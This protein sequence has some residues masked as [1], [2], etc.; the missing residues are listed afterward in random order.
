MR[1]NFVDTV[2]L[3]GSCKYKCERCSAYVDAQKDDKIHVSPNVLVLPL[4]RS[5][6]LGRF[7]KITKF[8]S[9][10]M[11]LDLSPYMSPDAPYEGTGPPIYR[12]YSVVVHLG[13]ALNPKP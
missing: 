7:S 12:L 6:S 1:K 4:K 3:E 11:D 5:V 9:F 2:A 13:L 10:P 8:V